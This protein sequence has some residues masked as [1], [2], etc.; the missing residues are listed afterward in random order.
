ML[1]CG[2]LSDAEQHYN[3]G[4]ELSADRLYQEAIEAYTRAIELDDELVNAYINRGNAYFQLGEYENALADLDQAVALDSENP[5]AFVNRSA[6]NILLGDLD[7]AKADLLTAVS[8]DASLCAN[9]P[10]DAAALASCPTE[11]E[12]AQLDDDPD[13]PGDYYPPHPGPDGIPDTRDDRIHVGLGVDVAICTQ[14][15]VEANQV[16]SPMCYTS[17]PPTSG[18]HA[19]MSAPLRVLENPAPKENL[20]H[21]MEH[22]AVVVWYNT[23]DQGVINQLAAIVNDRTNGRRFLVMTLYTEME[24]ETIALTAWTRLDKFPVDDFTPKRVEDF[25]AAH[26]RRFNSGGF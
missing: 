24:P 20:V 18:P 12:L 15:Q 11:Y 4:V 22:G 26:Q 13:L 7:A 5:L 25:I 3:N 23:A 1:A 16:S 17:N 6:A 2:G 8:L 19:A 10:A 14:A 9:L 21:S